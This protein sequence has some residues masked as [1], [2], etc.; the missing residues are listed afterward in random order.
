MRFPLNLLDPIFPAVGRAETRKNL[1]RLR[2]R[3]LAGIPATSNTPT[4][5]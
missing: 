1:A 2:R 3:I 4:L 5:D